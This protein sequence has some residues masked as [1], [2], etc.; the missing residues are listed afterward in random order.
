MKTRAPEGGFLSGCVQ[1]GAPNAICQRTFEKL[2]A[3]YTP[4]ELR[5]GRSDDLLQD[6]IIAANACR[7]G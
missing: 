2:E 6:V 3:E 5:L 7:K 4:A 1:R